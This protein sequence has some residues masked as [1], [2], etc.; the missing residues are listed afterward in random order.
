MKE[1]NPIRN[2]LCRD[3][4]SAFAKLS[5]PVKKQ[6]TD[7]REQTYA[8]MTEMFKDQTDMM[9]NWAPDEEPVPDIEKP[10]KK[11]NLPFES[12]AGFSERKDQGI[13]QSTDE[14]FQF[15]NKITEGFEKIKTRQNNIPQ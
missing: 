6:I 15:N 9:A 8:M 5:G 7:E 1:N 13:D 10:L 12:F 14:V 3:L 2:Q 4:Q 11:S